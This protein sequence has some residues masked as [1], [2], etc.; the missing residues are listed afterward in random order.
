MSEKLPSW[1]PE[2]AED[3]AVNSVSSG[4]PPVVLRYASLC[5][6]ESGLVFYW[7]RSGS[8]VF[9]EDH[10]FVRGWTPWPPPHTQLFTP[11][12]QDPSHFLCNL[13]SPECGHSCW[14]QSQRSGLVRALWV[15][16]TGCNA[17]P[18]HWLIQRMSGL[19]VSLIKS[20]K[21]THLTTL[22]NRISLYPRR[23]TKYKTC[24]R[25]WTRLCNQ[26]L[27]VGLL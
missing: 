9:V 8:W 20:H 27:C 11:P 18:F 2:G 4:I 25:S 21:Q 5:C 14:L 12:H 24:E 6:L 16:I 23:N 17:P 15:A 26:C 13:H 19:H 3:S 10:W 7:E 1:P 22:H